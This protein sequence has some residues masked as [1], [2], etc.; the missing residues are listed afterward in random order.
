MNLTLSLTESHQNQL[1]AHLFPGDGL[2]AVALALCGR[3]Q[4]ADSYG[5]LIHEIL[6]VPYDSCERATDFIRWRTDNIPEILDRAATKGFSVIKIH[7]HPNGFD[8]FSHEDDQSD[9][10]Y[11]E[12]RPFLD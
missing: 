3:R 12:L 4:G 1:Q 11:F 2:E 7:S 8:T 10:E 5:L 6:P 9:N